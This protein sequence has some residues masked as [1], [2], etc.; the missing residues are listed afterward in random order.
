MEINISLKRNRIG[1]IEAFI[2]PQDDVIHYKEIPIGITRQLS[3]LRSVVD[4][5]H[6]PVRL[7]GDLI[8]RN[9]LAAVL[10]I[11]AKIKGLISCSDK[12]GQK[13]Q[14]AGYPDAILRL[15]LFKEHLIAGLLRDRIVRAG[16]KLS[17]LGYIQINLIVIVEDQVI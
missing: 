5:L 1:E 12:G 3:Q 11:E 16:Q 9:L 10:Y 8:Q 15:P 13:I 7:K 4:N 2:C 17:I 6:N 14:V